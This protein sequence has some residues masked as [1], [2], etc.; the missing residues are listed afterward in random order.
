M[1]C[2]CLPGHCTSAHRHHEAAANNHPAPSSIQVCARRSVSPP[3]NHFSWFDWSHS[4]SLVRVNEIQQV[5]GQPTRGW[6]DPAGC[7]EVVARLW[8]RQVSTRT[9]SSRPGQSVTSG[10]SIINRASD[11]REAALRSHAHSLLTGCSINNRSDRKRL[12]L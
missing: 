11:D 3:S 5:S 1:L 12:I 2:V 6:A 4:G 10:A 9:S 8:S 7:R